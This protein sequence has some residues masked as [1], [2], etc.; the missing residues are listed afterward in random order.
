MARLKDFEGGKHDYVVYRE[1]LAVSKEDQ[2][3]N[4]SRHQLYIRK[5]EE[6][7]DSVRHS[8][9]VVND[10]YSGLIASMCWLGQDLENSGKPAPEVTPEKQEAHQKMHKYAGRALLQSEDKE[11]ARLAAVLSHLEH[12]TARSELLTPFH[13]TGCIE[14]NG[15]LV[16]RGDAL[17]RRGYQMTLDDHLFP[18][19][20]EA[21]EL[22]AEDNE[23]APKQGAAAKLNS[24][25][26]GRAPT[27]FASL[28]KVA[29]RE[30][31]SLDRRRA[32]YGRR[33]SRT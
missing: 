25:R 3:E 17:L 19:Y 26:G 31:T 6:M 18:E 7:S 13:P 1:D 30:K 16:P 28:R 22:L 32:L 10:C 20:Q 14:W 15:C 11:F 4:L 24:R 29:M 33:H 21:L 8:L 23:E 2:L 9:M 12:L 5:T 27:S